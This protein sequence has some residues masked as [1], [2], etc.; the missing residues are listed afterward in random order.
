MRRNLIPAP[1]AI[2]L[3]ATVLSVPVFPA[4][5]P[6]RVDRVVLYPDMAEVTRVVEV[7]RPEAT[8]VLPGLTPNLLPDTLSARVTSGGARI[9]GVSAED[10]FRTEPVDE[11]VGELTRR[12]EE[13]SDGKR[14]AEEG[15]AA[16]R[17]EKELLER[18]VLAIYAPAEATKDGEKGRPPRLSV[19]EVDAALSLYRARVEALD[20]SVFAND[21]KARDLEKK[22]AAARQELD[23][24]RNPRPTQEKVVRIDLAPAGKCRLA[25]TYRV[26][27]AGFVPRY[28]ARL[29]PGT[30]I[31]FLE[32][33]ADAWQRTG[34][35][36]KEATLAFSTARPGKTAQL[37]PLPPWELDFYQPPVARPMMKMRS[38]AA[39]AALAGAFA[40]EAKEEVFLPPPARRFAS[41]EANLEGRHALGGNGEKKAFLLARQEQKATVAWRAVPKMVEGAYLAANGRNETGLPV[42]SAPAAL[43]LE[44]AY[45]GRGQLPDIPEGEEFRIDFG[46]DPGV[47]IQRKE[48]ERKRE[49]GGVFAKVKRTRFRYEITA[50]NFRKETVPLTVLDQVPFPRHKEIVVKD[51]E[52]TGGGKAGEQGEITWELSLAAGEKKVLGLSFTVEYPA[53]KEIHGL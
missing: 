42:F 10:L 17:R 22:I 28:N 30:G 38:E 21:R 13:L 34:E 1:F 43:F 53:D 29:V 11:R 31:L 27:A 9:T 37:P 41:L 39:D 5:F 47:R 23:K 49:E 26:P 45:V 32:L 18:G 16:G 24:I 20:G 2:V 46:Q 19:A 15:A 50:Q 6:S 3:L 14:R 25:V 12:I 35:D 7:D 51:V 36:W 8:I 33:V 4:E 52:I 44:D 40:P 48:R